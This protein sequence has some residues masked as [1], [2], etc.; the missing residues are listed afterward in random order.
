MLKINEPFLE[1]MA[2]DEKSYPKDGL[3]EIVLVGR[4][5]VGKSSFINALTNRKKLA[6]TSSSPG[7]TRTINFYNIDNMFRIVDLPGYGYAKISMS[8]REKWKKIIE[9]Y[10]VKSQNIAL[11]CQIID[12]RHEP[13]KLDLMMYDYIQ[14]TGTDYLIIAN[15]LDKLKS[16][17]ILKQISIIKKSLINLEKDSLIPFSSQDKRGVKEVLNKFEEII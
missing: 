17:Q 2:V 3:K 12:V 14:S 8:E 16:S 4:S 9:E 5:N 11:I 1:R 13:T 7:K 10:L 6:Y 15:K